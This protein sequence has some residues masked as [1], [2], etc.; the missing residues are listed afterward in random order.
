MDPAPEQFV[1]IKGRGVYRPVGQVSLDRAI[2]MVDAALAYARRHGIRDVLVNGLGLTGFP[3]P[4]LSERFF[5]AE[6][7]A[8]TAG[9]AVRLSMVCHAHMI[10]PEK[11]GMTVANNRGLVSDVFDNE[12]DAVAWLDRLAPP[13]QLTV[14]RRVR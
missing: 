14:E 8:L 9:G 3:S 1:V 2:E 5:L 6:K 4:T 12:P 7:W 13:P 10:D 11:F